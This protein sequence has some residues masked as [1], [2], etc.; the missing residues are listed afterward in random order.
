MKKILLAVY[1][2][3]LVQSS[4]AQTCEEREAKLLYIFGG[5]TA[6]VLYN[7]YAFVGVVCDAYAKKT[8]DSAFAT[9]LLAEQIS[10]ISNQSKLNDTLLNAGYVRSAEDR[11]FFTDYIGLLKGIQQQAQH[12]LDFIKSKSTLKQIAYED[13]RQQNWEE[14][15]RL[16]GIE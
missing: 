12:Y 10:F 6:M 11:E 14:I 4:S 9:Q 13:Q 15:K 16:L 5:T 3:S 1:L 2:I 7:T 8:Y